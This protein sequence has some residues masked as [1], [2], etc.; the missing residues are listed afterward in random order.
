MPPQTEAGFLSTVIAYARL[1][2]WLVHH[3][4][5]AMSRTG[6]WATALSGDCGL[7]DLILVRA[8]K[9]LWLELKTDAG[10]LTWAQRQW[11]ERLQ[12]AGQEYHLF[13]PKDWPQIVKC[14]E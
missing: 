8:N 13:R 4:R 14:L 6:R 7:P 1:R 5:P 9:V 12:A 10:R 11:A 2:R 3:S